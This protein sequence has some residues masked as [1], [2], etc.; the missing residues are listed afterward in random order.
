MLAPATNHWPVLG[1]RNDGVLSPLVL[2]SE[3]CATPAQVEE[4]ISAALALDYVRFNKFMKAPHDGVIS[5]CGSAPSLLWTY[6]DTEGDILACN[7]AH[8]FLIDRNVI[9]KYEMLWDADAV[10]NKFFTP[11][12][13]VIYLVASRCHPDVFKRLEG[14]DV[15][16]WH[17]G[18][19]ECLEGLLQA[20]KRIEPMVNGGSAAVVRGMFVAFAMGYRKMH[21]FGVDSSYDELTHVRK[22]VV[23][24]QRLEVNCLG[25]WFKTTPWLAMQAEDFKI[26]GPALRD[27]GAEIVVHGTGL[28]PTIARD[29][30]FSTPNYLG[31]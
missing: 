10:I 1:A 3:I 14:F 25:K 26:I 15:V 31:D 16:V 12:K 22:S 24:E 5:I 30:G 8:D 2:K 11:R 13:G 23:E 9:P 6:E 7:A 19:D 28:V 27:A 4:N 18:G 17:A 20:A 21:L 29:F